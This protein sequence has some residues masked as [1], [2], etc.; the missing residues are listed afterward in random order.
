MH[1]G[2][3]SRMARKWWLMLIVGLIVGLGVGLGA[4]LGGANLKDG[5]FGLTVNDPGVGPFKGYVYREGTSQGVAGVNLQVKSVLENGATFTA[6]AR[7]D[8][9]GF[10]IAP[11]RDQVARSPFGRYEISSPDHTLAGIQ[12]PTVFDGQKA[13]ITGQPDSFFFIVYVK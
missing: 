6:Y 2:L 4:G 7:T 13:I 8:G 9:A 3:L 10:W 5:L 12:Q 1:A 11:I